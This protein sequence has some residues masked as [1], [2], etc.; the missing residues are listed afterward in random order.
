MSFEN[1]RRSPIPKLSMHSRLP[2][3]IDLSDLQAGLERTR[4]RASCV[5]LAALPDPPSPPSHRASTSVPTAWEVRS[6]RPGRRYAV[7]PPRCRSGALDLGGR[8]LKRFRTVRLDIP[9]ASSIRHWE[10]ILTTEDPSFAPEPERTTPHVDLTGPAPIITFK[11]P[12][13]A[14]LRASRSIEVPEGKAGFI[15][16][17]NCSPSIVTSTP[18][19]RLNELRGLVERARSRE[20]LRADVPTDVAAP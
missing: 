16:T 3:R 19:A 7:A 17:R 5:D 15:G 6:N 11:G 4:P 9:A 1:M 10:L 12:A 13:A 20:E 2:G 18:T 8:L 14:F